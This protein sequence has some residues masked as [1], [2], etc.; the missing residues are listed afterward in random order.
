MCAMFRYYPAL[1]AFSLEPQ[2][3]ATA[4]LPI[5]WYSWL[6]GAFVVSLV[7]A[8]LMPRRLAERLPHA[9]VWG[10]NLAVIVGIMVYERRWFY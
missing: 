2:P 1:G 3:L 9:W 8:L 5:N 4:G 7:A 6:L 10:V